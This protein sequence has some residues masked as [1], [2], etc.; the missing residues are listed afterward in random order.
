MKTPSSAQKK[1]RWSENEDESPAPVNIST[2]ER[3]EIT[4]YEELLGTPASA[5][6][7]QVSRKEKKKKK[8]REEEEVF[9]SP[10]SPAED[11]QVSRK[12]RKKM[13]MKQEEEEFRSPFSPAEDGQVSRKKKEKLMQEKEEETVQAGKKK[14]K[15]RS[16]VEEVTSQESE[17]DK[18]KQKKKKHKASVTTATTHSNSG[19]TDVSVSMEAVNSRMMV[20]GND[21][22]VEEVTSHNRQLGEKE[23]VKLAKIKKGVTEKNG[24]KNNVKAAATDG[25]DCKLLEE[26]QEFIPDVKQKSADQ[27]T[28]LLRYDLARLR[29]FKKQGVSLRMGRFSR[30]ENQQIIKNVADF[31]SLTGIGSA[32]QLLFPQRFKDH[33]EQIKKLKVQ[34]RFLENIAEGI[35]RTCDQVYI[36]AKKIFDVTNSMGRFSTD[37]LH[38]LIKLQKLHGNN[39]KT[40]SEKMDRSIYALQKRFNTI[41]SGRG[42]WTA[43]EASRLKQAVRDHLETQQSPP[44]LTRDQLCNNLPWK[45]ISEQVETRSWVQCRLKWFSILKPKLS[46]KGKVFNRGTEGYIAKIHLIN[47]LYEM[48]VD[49]A[50]DISWDEVAEAIG[51]VTPVCVQK[52]FYRLKVSRV[53]NWTRL[54]Y[55]DII[56]FLKANVVPVLEKKLKKCQ[57][58]EAQEEEAEGFYQLSDIF[59]EHDDD[60]EVDN[61]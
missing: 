44:G 31:L 54:S 9:K 48:R 8:R 58:E 37:E 52:T 25:L 45:K 6:D 57:E 20:E 41:T 51:K 15:D 55:S 29:I 28:K 26:L 36:R 11:G 12:K 13:N 27:I 38:S 33:A 46:S 39:W 4:D 23:K 21:E 59:S 60:V 34:H 2:P 35:A 3:E 19:E 30:E 50:A 18:T 47:T 49:D 16:T 42:S 17:S 53:P 24:K 5:E 56:D 61:S 10:F 1:R 43:E 22:S 7:G 40:I 14:T 32:D